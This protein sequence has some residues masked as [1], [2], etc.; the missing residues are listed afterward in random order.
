MS[1]A[2][3]AGAGGADASVDRPAIGIDVGGSKVAAGLVGPD[4]T[5]RERRTLATPTD[6][7][8]EVEDTIV[9]LV[10][11][12]AGADPL[13]VGIGAAG[14]VDEH[15]EVVRF[16]PHLAWRSEPLAHR[17]AERVRVPVLV[18]ND[19]NA[20]AWAEYR[21]GAGAGASPMVMITLGTGIG[22]GLVIDGHLFRGR[23]GM[24]G[25]WGHVCVVPDGQMCPCG[26]RGCWEQY[27]SGQAMARE[28]Q[29]LVAAG[30]PVAVGL[31]EHVADPDQV[32]GRDVTA[33]ALAGDLACIDI[34]T[35]VGEWL[36]RGI[37]GL[38]AVLD[39]ERFVVGGGVSEAGELLMGPARAAFVRHLTGRGFRPEADLCLARL[40][41]DAG[42]IGAA[43]LARRE[44]SRAEVPRDHPAPGTG[45]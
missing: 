28:A 15:R 26:N 42:M 17:L 7:A 25:E 38:A 39:A 10:A 20:A 44:V 40:G 34:V 2:P 41:N 5:I 3:L 23:W 9:E 22:G 12:W 31:L 45:A 27:C 8:R 21:F 36:G 35:G 19:A 18:D 16:S 33:A 32:V 43:E 6:S 11:G 30:S 4:G 13:A 14:W 24:A 29:A 1:I 37:A